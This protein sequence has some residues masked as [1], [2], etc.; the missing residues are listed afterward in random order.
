MAA[1]T[2]MTPCILDGILESIEGLNDLNHFEDIEEF[3]DFSEFLND[4]VQKFLRFSRS[5]H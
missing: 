1:N 4:F 5:F 2:V 3:N